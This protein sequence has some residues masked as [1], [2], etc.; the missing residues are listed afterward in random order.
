MQLDGL[1]SHISQTIVGHFVWYNT[2]AQTAWRVKKFYK[3]DWKVFEK[4]HYF[5]LTGCILALG[6]LA[7]LITGI[8]MFFNFVLIQFPLL[9]SSS[10]F[11]ESTLYHKNNYSS[12]CLFI[13][14]TLLNTFNKMSCDNKPCYLFRQSTVPVTSSVVL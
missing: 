13:I 12:Y 14:N 1:Q 3:A 6:S 9:T 8:V 7:V 4:C 5:L 10:N 2:D 11:L